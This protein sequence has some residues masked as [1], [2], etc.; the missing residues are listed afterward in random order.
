MLNYLKHRPMLISAIGVAGASVCAFY[1]SAAL[2]VYSLIITT[3]LFLAIVNKKKSLAVALILVLFVI[4]S[5]F[6]AL[7]KINELNNYRKSRIEAQVTV[8]ETTYKSEKIYR[9]D[10]E[11]IKSD[12]LKRGEKLSVWHEPAVINAGDKYQAVIVVDRVD[13]KYKASSYSKGIYLSGSAVEFKSTGERDTVLSAVGSIRKYIKDTFFKNM[14]YDCAATLFALVVG[15]MDYLSDELYANAKGA[16]VLHAMVVSGMHLTVLV[17]LC[18]SFTEKFMHNSV[19]K[20]VT[21]LFVVTAILAVCGFTMSILRA[22]ATYVIMAVGVLLNKSYS[23]ENALGAAVCLITLSS[24]FAIHSVGFQLSVLSTFGILAVTLPICGFLESRRIVKSKTGLFLC[25]AVIISL[26]ASLLTLPVIIKV[27]G[28]VSTLS[29]LSNLL[30]DYPVTLSLSASVI[31]LAL[32]LIFPFGAKIVFF[33]CELLVKYINGVINLLGSKRFS[34]IT[35]PQEWAYI[36]VAVIFAVFGLML[37]CKKRID[38]LKLKEMNEKI[39]KERGR[40][41]KWQSFMKISLKN[42]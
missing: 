32:T 27:F 40:R 4:L 6:V 15:D 17:S 29:V 20:A 22:G 1:S 13:E 28:C 24:P 8:L 25:Q 7:I 19:L 16:G 23:G 33:F 5:C 3:G 12:K 14:D 39:K 26:S 2:F 38:M 35:V 34:V 37:T 41:K 31:G 36:S 10:I 11:I 30:I 21:M 9:S 18:L 42:K